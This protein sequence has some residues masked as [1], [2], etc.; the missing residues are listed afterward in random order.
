[1]TA[2]ADIFHQTLYSPQCHT[3]PAQPGHRYLLLMFWAEF[4]TK[5]ERLFMAARLKM[6]G[7]NHSIDEH[8]FLL[9]NVQLLVTLLTHV[10]T[11]ECTSHTAP[12]IDM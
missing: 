9:H 4:H 7:H 1:M 12:H 2:L 5:V 11:N 10:H 6:G 3:Y 8:R